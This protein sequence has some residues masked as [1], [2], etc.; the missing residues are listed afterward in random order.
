M[1]VQ[2]EWK[3][4]FL[5]EC[6]SIIQ[7]ATSMPS[8]IPEVTEALEDMKA[9]IARLQKLVKDHVQA[10]TPSTAESDTALTLLPGSSAQGTD[11]VAWFPILIHHAS[12]ALSGESISPKWSEHLMHEIQAFLSAVAVMEK[13]LS[14]NK[15]PE[16]TQRDLIDGLA[17]MKTRVM[18]IHGVLKKHLPPVSDDTPPKLAYQLWL[19]FDGLREKYAHLLMNPRP[20]KHFLDH[21]HASTVA[22]LE[23]VAIVVDHE[24]T[25]PYIKDQLDLLAEEVSVAATRMQGVHVLS[26]AVCVL[27]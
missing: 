22:F 19:W 16:E 10:D 17:D 13:E 2:D 24:G 5:A 3:S 14:G 7:K 23:D 6:D 11:L 8:H 9:R 25:N 12:I 21:V 18:L 27:F 4:H 1:T 20:S 15:F 26:G